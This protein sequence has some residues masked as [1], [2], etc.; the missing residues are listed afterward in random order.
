MRSSG[1]IFNQ[2]YPCHGQSGHRPVGSNWLIK[3]NPI[4]I[5]MDEF[6]I[7]GW[8]GTAP[9]DVQNRLVVFEIPYTQL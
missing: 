9:G 5:N 6:K 8:S 1:L 4:L 7:G 3:Q 2:R